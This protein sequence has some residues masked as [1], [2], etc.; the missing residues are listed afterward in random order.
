MPEDVG[1]LT[2]VLN[3]FVDVFRA[4]Y[5]RILPDALWL[6]Q[7]FALLEVV[8]AALWYGF[9]SSGALEDFLR[10]VL[11]IG[12][13]IFV[14]TE[15]PL[16]FRALA[17]GFTQVGLKAG[18][19]AIDLSAFWDPSRIAGFGIAATEPIFTQVRSF[20][21]FR[22]AIA[23]LPN[24]LL[25]LVVALIVILAFFAVAI[26]VFVTILE[27]YLVAVLGLILIPFGVFRPTAGFAEGVFG[28]IFTFGV[29]LMVLAFI[30]S[31]ADPIMA[32]LTEA[33]PSDPQLRQTFGLLLAA[34]TLALLAWSAPGLA[35]GLV[36]GGPSLTAGT[37]AGTAAATGLGLTLAGAGALGAT[38]SA[39]RLGLSSAQGALGAANRALTAYQLGA[40]TTVGGPARQIA[41]GLGGVGATAGSA[42]RAR[43]RAAVKNGRVRG[44][45]PGAG[46]LAARTVSRAELLARAVPPESHPQGEGRVSLSRR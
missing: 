22:E 44:Y 5:G 24:N 17:E 13:F 35:A 1:I 40:A 29:K 34:I 11:V 38:R 37:F 10:K 14:V 4:G 16:L 3:R 45:G 9:A 6:L 43:F 42:L 2:W 30:L 18:G 36:R 20:S 31:A 7:A 8:L 21:G 15:L 28:G 32:S 39:S 25:L 33:I 41:G 12:F 46:D 23:N 26:Q 27:F 19:G